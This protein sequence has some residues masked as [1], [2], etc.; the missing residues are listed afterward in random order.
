M[1][2]GTV[3]DLGKTT[4]QCEAV[5]RVTSV[6]GADTGVSL[7]SRPESNEEEEKKLGGSG[8]APRINF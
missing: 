4:S 7:N 3:L 2:S 6:E 8:V 5:P 1:F